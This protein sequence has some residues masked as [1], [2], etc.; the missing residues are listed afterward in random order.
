M[1]MC[2]KGKGFVFFFG[3]GV[4][5]FNVWDVGSKVPGLRF[6]DFGFGFR[7]SGSGFGVCCLGLR[8]QDLGSWVRARA[9][10]LILLLLMLLSGA[11][12]SWAQQTK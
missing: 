5:G 10:L 3:L 12:I 4:W 8:P 2:Y 1:G 9:R 11:F 6:L 7:V